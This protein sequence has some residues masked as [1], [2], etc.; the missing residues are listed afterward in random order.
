MPP[1]EEV[2]AFVHGMAL[3]I[4]VVG[5]LISMIVA[6]YASDPVMS[7][8]AL[9]FAIAFIL[10]TGQLGWTLMVIIITLIGVD[11]P[12]TAND[13][14]PLGRAR[15]ILGTL[16]LIIPLFCFTPFRVSVA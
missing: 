6:L 8:H 3:L 1:R 2:V 7:F 13:N 5:A 16:S 11:H 9:I 4:A 14:V 15:A 12:P 10:I